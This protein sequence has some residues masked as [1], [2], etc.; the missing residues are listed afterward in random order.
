VQC[1]F[2]ELDNCNSTMESSRHTTRAWSSFS[3]VSGQERLEDLQERYSLSTSSKLVFLLSSTD[4]VILHSDMGIVM[5]PEEAEMVAMSN[6]K[7][8]LSSEPAAVCQ[9]SRGW[10]QRHGFEAEKNQRVSSFRS[11]LHR[12]SPASMF[13]LKSFL[14]SE[15]EFPHEYDNN[16]SVHNLAASLRYIQK[17]ESKTVIE[18]FI[19][20]MRQRTYWWVSLV[21]HGG[22]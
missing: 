5:C 21:F 6:T 11:L 4:A 9:K 19:L 2:Q 8:E 12:S 14:L 17:H 22:K 16:R 15:W 18:Y 20:H 7:D 1:D 3:V 10:F 13:C